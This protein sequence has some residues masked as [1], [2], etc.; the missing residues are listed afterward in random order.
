MPLTFRD[1]FQDRGLPTETEADAVTRRPLASGVV[2]EQEAGQNSQVEPYS[3]SRRS[4]VA[5]SV[6]ATRSDLQE[7]LV[8]MGML[9]SKA[10]ERAAVLVENGYTSVEE[11]E[12]LMAKHAFLELTVTDLEDNIASNPKHPGITGSFLK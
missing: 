7:H 12:A 6:D 11:F 8:V 4:S 9:R 2:E 10:R 1:P 5:S 3:L